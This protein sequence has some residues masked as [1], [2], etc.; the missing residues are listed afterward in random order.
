M[1]IFSKHDLAYLIYNVK[2]DSTENQIVY[3]DFK[4]IDYAL[5]STDCNLCDCHSIYDYTNI[6]SQLTVLQYNIIY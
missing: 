5:L 1:P 4:N 6:T 2:T 3:R